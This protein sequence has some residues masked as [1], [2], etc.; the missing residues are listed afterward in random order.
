MEE[1]SLSQFL[2]P[3]LLEFTW[4]R[5]A[6]VVDAISKQEFDIWLANLPDLSAVEDVNDALPLTGTEVVEVLSTDSNFA[7][8]STSELKQLQ[9]KNC[10]KNTMKTSYVV[11]QV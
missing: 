6:E 3:S 4:S 9:E 2:S 8:T 7:V 5:D 11:E 10:N 1:Q